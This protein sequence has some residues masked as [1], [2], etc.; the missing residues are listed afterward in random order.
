MSD[1]RPRLSFRVVVGSIVFQLGFWLLTVF[2]ALLSFLVFFWL[3]YP[4]RF[5]GITGWGKLSVRWLRL[6]CGIKWQVVGAENIP[7]KAAVVVCNHQS[8]WETLLLEELFVPQ[9]FVIKKELLRVPF[10]GWGISLLYP[11]AIDRK[12]K[13]KALNQLIDQSNSALSKERWV[14]LFPEGTRTSPLVQVPYKAGFGFL[15]AKIDRPVVPLVHNAGYLW[16]RNSFWKYPGNITVSILPAV[17]VGDGEK[18]SEFISR[19][20][21]TMRAE[22]ARLGKPNAS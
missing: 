16:P 8:T 7:E 9:V 20:E 13:K 3:P 17:T 22:Q 10:F 1:F 15:A 18:V 19:V 12:A 14:I 2:W 21:S 4:W 5:K 11:I 6:T